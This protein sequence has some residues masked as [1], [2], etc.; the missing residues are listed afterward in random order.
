MLAAGW[1]AAHTSQLRRPLNRARNRSSNPDRWQGSPQLVVNPVNS[2]RP[3]AGTADAHVTGAAQAVT[4]GAAHPEK[5]GVPHA[6][7]HCV[8]VGRSEASLARSRANRPTRGPHASVESHA[9][10]IGLYTA[11]A[12]VL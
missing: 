2:G 4:T 6:G 10:G 11:G 5:I 9:D 12:Q 7:A 1:G 8:R 3:Q